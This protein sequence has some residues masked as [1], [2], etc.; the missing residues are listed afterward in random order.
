MHWHSNEAT[1]V[2]KS[3]TLSWVFTTHSPPITTHVRGTIR[4]SG[5]ILKTGINTG[6]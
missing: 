3:K 2:R 6:G 5:L 4:S 1:N